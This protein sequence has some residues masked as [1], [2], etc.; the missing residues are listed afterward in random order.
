MARKKKNAAP[1][2]VPDPVP[3]PVLGPVQKECWCSNPLRAYWCEISRNSGIRPTAWCLP[4][5][6]NLPPWVEWQWHSGVSP[7]ERNL[8]RKHDV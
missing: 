7:P 3:D 1:A 6:L 4:P 2:V 8:K 5:D